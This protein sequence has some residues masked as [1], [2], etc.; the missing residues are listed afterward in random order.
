MGSNNNFE[1]RLAVL[2]LDMPVPKPEK[3]AR[4]SPGMALFSA[5]VGLAAGWLL[6]AAGHLP[7][8]SM[9]APKPAAS[10]V[11][12]DTEKGVTLFGSGI[13]SSRD[14]SGRPGGPSAPSGKPGALSAAG[15]VE[16]VPPGPVKVSPMV[17]GRLS[18]VLCVPGDPVS[19]GQKVAV[20]DSSPYDQ[21]AA[22][23]ATR[24][25]LALR[26]LENLEAG[27]PSQEIEGAR[28]SL[29][30]ARARLA[31]SAASH[32][33]ARLLHGKG[34]VSAGE[35][36]LR[37][38]EHLQ[39]LA[40]RDLAA[41]ELSRLEAGARPEELAVARA[42]VASAKA[43]LAMV[44]WKIR[45]CELL[46]PMDGVV[47]DLYAE[48]GRWLEAGADSGDSAVLSIFGPDDIQVWTDV[49]QRNMP[50]V[51]PGRKVLVEADS[52]PGVRVPGLVERVLPGANRQ[53]NTFQVKIVLAATNGALKPEASVRIEFLDPEDPR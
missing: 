33:R 20:L 13:E 40:A 27:Y 21:E 16:V 12:T 11:N 43:E 45:N 2:R 38:S 25:E 37:K 14:A 29:E 30:R 34:S 32:E 50:W 35:L 47:L 15:Y 6:A 41:A 23:V 46:S 31:Y 51:K 52:L 22:L 44:E 53:K 7:I 8:L 48:P 3:R 19:K 39:D 1:D 28:A 17:S 10:V 5:F 18:K 24:V 49:S 36:E 42:E 4:N 26:R 9:E